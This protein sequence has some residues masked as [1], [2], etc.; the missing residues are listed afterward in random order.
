MHS[1]A[2]DCLGWSCS[3][4]C[5]DA[6]SPLTLQDQLLNEAPQLQDS[7][8]DLWVWC[9]VCHMFYHLLCTL[10]P[11]TATS[12]NCGANKCR[13]QGIRCNDQNVQNVQNLAANGDS[14]GYSFLQ[15]KTKE[16]SKG[17][18]L[19]KDG[20]T[21]SP[22]APASSGK[23]RKR[24]KW[25]EKQMEHAFRLHRQDPNMPHTE[26]Q[27]LTTVKGVYI[28]YTTLNDRLGGRRGHGTGYCAGGK[29]TPRVLNDGKSKRGF[30]GVAYG[31]RY[32]KFYTS[33]F[34]PVLLCRSRKRL[35]WYYNV[36]LTMWLPI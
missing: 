29:R 3:M 20:R 15:A 1:Y 12:N 34:P 16:S 14:N 13:K 7:N 11:S 9:E 2:V 19:V 26:I 22:R 27:R 6:L 31:Y 32:R 24:Q 4:C 8:G 30:T 33:K 28:P 23:G 21:I 36:L 35:G 10:N 5:L 25:T 17:R 18:R